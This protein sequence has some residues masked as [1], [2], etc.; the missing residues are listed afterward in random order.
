M[1][2]VE[3]RYEIFASN[4][5]APVTT[6][7]ASH[8]FCEPERHVVVAAYSSWTGAIVV[9]LMEK[10]ATSGVTLWNTVTVGSGIDIDTRGRTLEEVRIFGGP[11]N[12]T[13]RY[14]AVW[15]THE[16]NEIISPFPDIFLERVCNGCTLGLGHRGTRVPADTEVKF[17]AAN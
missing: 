15:P 17:P 3:G 8:S 16:S 1:G 2:I 14:I 4:T 9:I 13:D 6:G 5:L 12:Y 10:T 7:S 11:P